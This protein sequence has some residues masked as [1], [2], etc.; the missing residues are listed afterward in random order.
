MANQKP[1][2]RSTYGAFGP[3]PRPKEYF[4]WLDGYRGHGVLITS[5]ASHYAALAFVRWVF[6]GVEKPGFVEVHAQRE[7]YAT[8]M[9][10]TYKYEI[11]FN[12]NGM[13]FVLEGNKT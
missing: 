6:E 2:L 10:R 1:T 3:Q 9:Q 11:G 13:P 12:K 8:A 4:V 5:E 7:A